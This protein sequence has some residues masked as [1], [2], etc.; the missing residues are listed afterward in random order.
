[1]SELVKKCPIAERGLAALMDGKT[2]REAAELQ[3]FG[4][5]KLLNHILKSPDG[6]RRYAQALMGKGALYASEIVSI[7]DRLPDDPTQNQVAKAK[8]RV[9]ARQWCATKFWQHLS[10]EV[11]AKSQLNVSLNTTSDKPLVIQLVNGKDEPKPVDTI[12]DV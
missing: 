1:M 6:E 8:L 11:Q 12:T 3:G 2:I 9:E 4:K 10:N 7:A 5:T